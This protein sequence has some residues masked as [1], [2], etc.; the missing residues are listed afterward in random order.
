MAYIYRTGYVSDFTINSEVTVAHF[1]QEKIKESKKKNSP[2]KYDPFSIK[3]MI[4]NSKPFDFDRYRLEECWMEATDEF[5]ELLEQLP[6]AVE[7]ETIKH[8][9]ENTYQ[10]AKKKGLNPNNCFQYLKSGS[11]SQ[12]DLLDINRILIQIRSPFDKFYVPITIVTQGPTLR[13]DHQ[14]YLTNQSRIDAVYNK[15]QQEL[16]LQDSNQIDFVPKINQ[17]NCYHYLPESMGLV[18]KLELK[19]N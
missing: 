1:Y 4:E 15:N 5:T 14:F 13:G 17:Y 12:S 16:I 19:K 7:E 2:M 6:E 18:K 3:G 9:L 10:Y 8:R 11:Q